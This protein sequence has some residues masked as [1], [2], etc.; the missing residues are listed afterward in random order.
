MTVPTTLT[1][2]VGNWKA[3]NRLWLSPDEPVRESKVTASV[4][5]AA[6]GQFI[7]IAY[8]WAEDG[9]QD[10]L[11]MIGQAA[12]S[13]AVKAAWIDSWHNGDK[14]M[15][16]EGSL[17]TEGAVSVKGSYPAPSGPDWGWRIVIEPQANDAWRM[18]MYNIT[19]EGQEQLA[20]EASFTR[21]A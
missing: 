17:S 15:L 19:S 16:C 13:N 2:L 1:T 4:A 20:V 7:T 6:Q 10:G 14:L 9:P 11:L 21:Q 5:L 18:V 12:Q 8:T 3:T